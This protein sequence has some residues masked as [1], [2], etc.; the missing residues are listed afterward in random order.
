WRWLRWFHNAGHG[1]MAATASLADELVSRGFRSVLRWAHGVDARLFRPRPDA[2]LGL[3]RPIFLAVSRLTAEENIA[4]FLSLD[5][6]GT[7][8]VVGE[9]PARDELAHKCPNAVFLGARHGEDLARVYAAADV[10][11]FPSRSDTS[12]EVLLEALACGT[13]IASF[14]VAATRDVA[15]T[16]PVAVL[17]DDLRAACIGAL[18][19]SRRACRDYAEKLTWEASARR[20]LA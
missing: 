3:L 10:L 5:L 12:G 15:G 2:T 17:D 20:F 18:A 1:T 19:L 16:A 11:V 13:P 14:P 8:V 9:G 6:P 7:K 4:A